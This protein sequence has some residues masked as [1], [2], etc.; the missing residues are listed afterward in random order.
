MVRRASVWLL[1]FIAAATA[2]LSGYGWWFHFSVGPT[3]GAG[4]DIGMIAGVASI[5]SL[6]LGWRL[7]RN[8]HR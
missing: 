2:L 1:L 3:H 8:R 5:V 7:S 6:A 4:R